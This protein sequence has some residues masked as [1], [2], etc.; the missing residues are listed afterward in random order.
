MH[1]FAITNPKSCDIMSKKPYD[2]VSSTV[3]LS[4][5]ANAMPIGIIGIR[6][7]AP[8][9]ITIPTRNFKVVE[10][11]ATAIQ[12]NTEV[13]MQKTRVISKNFLKHLSRMP[14]IIDETTP[15]KTT[16]IPRTAMLEGVK[17][18][19]DGFPKSGETLIPKAVFKP[20]INEYARESRM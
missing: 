8:T 18:N 20:T 5:A 17:S 9:I 15:K 14:D 11:R 13:P 10:K 16:K 4:S 1:T 2:T 12:R 6:N 7:M 3:Q 19:P